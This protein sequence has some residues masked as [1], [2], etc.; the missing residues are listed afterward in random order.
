MIRPLGF[1]AITVFCSAASACGEGNGSAAPEVAMPS[2]S[3]TDGMPSSGT[4]EPADNDNGADTGS[5]SP[6]GSTDTPST[7]SEGNPAPGAG[8]PIEGT[9]IEGTPDAPLGGETPLD[10][11]LRTIAADDAR[12]QYSGRIDFQNPLAPTYSAPAASVSVRFAG[13]SISALLT[14]EFRYGSERGYHDVI[15]DGVITKKL[16]MEPGVEKYELATGLP[17]GE[18]SARLVKR[19]QASLGKSSFKGFELTGDLLEPAAKPALKI[20][21]IGDS[22]TAGEGVE[23][24]NGS[25]ECTQNGAGTVGA[26]WGQPFHNADRSYGVVTAQ[27][28]DAEYH[29]TAVSGIGLVR[30]YS[31]MYDARPMPEVYDLM[32]VEETA[33]GPWD[34]GTFVPDVVVIALGTNDFSPGDAPAN[35]PR[36]QL[37]VATYTDAYVAFVS[38][39]RG[40]YPN[41]QIF[42]L[43]SQ[44]LGDDPANG[45]TPASDL[46]AAIAG[47]VARLNGAGDAKVHA[48]TPTQVSGQ[49]CSF[50]PDVAQQ[51]LLGQELAAEI[52]SVL[53]P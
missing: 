28:L 41:A 50:H 22:I 23:G 27:A 18:H 6:S 37:A 32:F 34:T 49:G 47:A 7:P 15:I 38:E 31:Q 43:S 17:A 40:N 11:S 26:G 19:T 13:T 44:L 5:P 30:N 4:P 10:L 36:P 33:S 20:E 14:D 3:P 2:G 52:R 16:M 53:T 8:T 9:P 46:R 24:V 1:V 51:E 21:F 39:L 12:I 42:A 25:P 29:L 35:T 45:Y 48:F